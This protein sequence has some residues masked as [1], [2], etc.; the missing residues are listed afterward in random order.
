VRRRSY[1]TNALIGAPDL[2]GVAI[3]CAAPPP[4]PDMSRRQLIIGG[5]E[6]ACQNSR[7]PARQQYVIVAASGEAGGQARPAQAG[8]CER[9]SP[10]RDYAACGGRPHRAGRQCRVSAALADRFALSISQAGRH[11]QVAGRPL[12]SSQFHAGNEPNG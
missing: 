10:G 2:L 4:P 9:P 12:V 1:S 8:R 7:N 6:Q 5:P 11:R 3:F